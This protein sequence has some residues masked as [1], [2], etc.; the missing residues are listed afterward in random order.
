V[1]SEA[2][3]MNIGL[4]FSKEFQALA[5]EFKLRGKGNGDV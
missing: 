3:I 1:A 4:P 5:G 2:T